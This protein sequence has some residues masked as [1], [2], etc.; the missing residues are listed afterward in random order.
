MYSVLRTLSTVKTWHLLR[1]HALAQLNWLE[2]RI[3]RESID[4]NGPVP[5]WTYGCTYY[6]DQV[7]PQNF[8]I[9]ELGGGNSTLWWLSRGNTVVTLET[10]GEWAKKLTREINET[11]FSSDWKLY[12]V[13]DINP[14]T[15]EEKL[16]VRKFDL[17][18]NDGHGDRSALVDSLLSRL[19][20]KG[21]LVWD[22][23]D[24]A[25][26]KINLKNMEKFGFKKLEF[27][28][29]SP[30]NAYCSKTTLFSK[31]FPQPLGKDIRYSE[32]EY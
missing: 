6:L 32:I 20:N 8:N 22:N 24:R 27:F 28:G 19:S 2:S 12:E 1:T 3:S 11:N 4:P 15:I 21:I 26:Y 13:L 17:I 29:V 23:S 31:D 7:V 10:N 25:Q 18:V 16:G 14:N 30:I 5:W 9:L